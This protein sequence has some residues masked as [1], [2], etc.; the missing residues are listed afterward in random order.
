MDIKTLTK[1]ILNDL[2][3]EVITMPLVK[4]YID[5]GSQSAEQ[6]ADLGR[7]ITD[8]IVK[9]TK[10]PQEFVWV[11]IHEMP[12]EDWLVD[13]LTVVELKKKLAESKK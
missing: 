10:M 8:V 12:E 3:R 4:V 2:Y 1:V 6:R 11:M 9:E 13:R 5:K 7:K